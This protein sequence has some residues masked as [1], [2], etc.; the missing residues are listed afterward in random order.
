MAF[1]KKQKYSSEF[2]K[3]IQ[4]K[5]LYTEPLFLLDVEFAKSGGMSIDR[6]K[7]DVGISDK[8]EVGLPIKLS[9]S[10]EL[11]RNISAFSARDV[12]SKS[13][14]S[15][16]LRNMLLGKPFGTVKLKSI[17]DDLMSSYSRIVS[18]YDKGDY[19]KLLFEQDTMASFKNT[20][21]KQIFVVDFDVSNEEQANIAASVKQLYFGQS[22]GISTSYSMRT[23]IDSAKSLNYKLKVAAVLTFPSDALKPYAMLFELE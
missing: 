17:R 7:S 10:P 14:V 4:R 3:S 18:T 19:A 9:H 5:A 21:K 11:A 13:S 12:S 8:V 2:V 16:L 6:S 20:S 1:N 22:S 23:I 15:T